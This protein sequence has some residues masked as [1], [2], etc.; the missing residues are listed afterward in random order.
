MK[1]KTRIANKIRNKNPNVNPTPSPTISFLF[2]VLKKY[3]HFI[4]KEKN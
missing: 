4:K 2:Y 1:K 3:F